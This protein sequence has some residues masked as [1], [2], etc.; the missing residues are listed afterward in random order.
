MTLY[1]DQSIPHR[2][3]CWNNK[4]INLIYSIINIRLDT[5]RQVMRRPEPVEGLPFASY[6]YVSGDPVSGV[7]LVT[8]WELVALY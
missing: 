4:S 5:G 8:A 6:S 7:T 2:G 3:R 1:W